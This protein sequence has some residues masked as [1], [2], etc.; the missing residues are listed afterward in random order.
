MLVAS[1]GNYRT[2]KRPS[3]DYMHRVPGTVFTASNP[4][5]DDQKP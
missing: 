5:V 3:V 2:L 1:K 4:Y